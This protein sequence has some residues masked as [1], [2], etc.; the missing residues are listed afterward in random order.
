ML[1]I[2]CDQIHQT[3]QNKLFLCLKLITVHV[4]NSVIKCIQLKTYVIVINTK[5]VIFC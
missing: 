1:V 3:L 2:Y 4:Q 5:L